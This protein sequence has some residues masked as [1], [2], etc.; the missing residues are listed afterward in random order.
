M[1]FRRGRNRLSGGVVVIGT[2]F[3]VAVVLPVGVRAADRTLVDRM[4]Q[5]N[6][7]YRSGDYAAALEAYRKIE[8]GCPGCAEPVYNQ[9]LAYYR[10]N[11]FDKAREKFN[12]ALSHADADLEARAKYN[13]G[14]VAY[15]EALADQA[16]VQKAIEKARSAIDFYRDALDLRPDDQDA[17]ANVEVAQRLVK[18][19]LKKQQ[20]QKQQQQKQD[21]KKQQNQDQQKQD[22]QQ[23]KQQQNQQGKNKQQSGNRQ[24]QEQK[25]DAQSGSKD[26]QRE[27]GSQSQDKQQQQAE[28]KPQSSESDEQKQQQASRSDQKQDQAGGKPVQARELTREEAERLLQAVRDKEAR[29]RAQLARIRRARRVPVKRDW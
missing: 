4:Q 8:Q 5:A 21:R 25:N 18:T 17:R 10:L 2:A 7:L 28:K 29:R 1:M 15:A 9:G 26:K 13:L 20:Q 14:D 22:R 3:F 23:Q 27:D 24:D 12:E 11:Q 6:E 16:N 19:L